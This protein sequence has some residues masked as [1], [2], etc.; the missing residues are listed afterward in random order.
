MRSNPEA[1]SIPFDP[2]EIDPDDPFEIDD[3]NRPHLAKHAGFS[4]EDVLD[5][6]SDEPLLIAPARPGPADWLMLAEVPGH[7]VVIVP[8]ASPRTSRSRRCRPIGIY[9]AGRVETRRHRLGS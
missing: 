6:W 8:L 1:A 5:A 2:N 4:E 7:G 9:P 3:D